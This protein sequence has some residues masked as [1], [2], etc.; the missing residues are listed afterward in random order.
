MVNER[1]PSPGE[2]ETTDMTDV[3]QVAQGKRADLMKQID[4]LMAEVEELDDFISFGKSLVPV[5]KDHEMHAQA[6]E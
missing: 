2:M 3:I 5:G 1:G 6:A 4:D